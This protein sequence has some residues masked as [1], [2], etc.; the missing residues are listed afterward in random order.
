[1]ETASALVEGSFCERFC[2]TSSSAEDAVDFSCEEEVTSFLS[3][4]VLSTNIGSALSTII[5]TGR[6]LSGEPDKSINIAWM[7][8]VH[9]KV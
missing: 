2:P 6:L 4:H 9:Y 8:T 5:A 1:M 7:I 3:S